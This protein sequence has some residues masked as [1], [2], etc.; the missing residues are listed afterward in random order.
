MN[1]KS[2]HAGDD[3]QRAD[4][5]A[6]VGEPI[7]VGEIPADAHISGDVFSGVDSVFSGTHSMNS[8]L[9]RK[10]EI[11]TIITAIVIIAVVIAVVNIFLS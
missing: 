10:R 8:G 4:S 2:Y 5:L 1:L 6:A 7:A 3:G 9:E 11:S